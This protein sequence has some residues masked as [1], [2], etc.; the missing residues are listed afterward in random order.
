MTANF[1]SR[2]FAYAAPSGYKA[3]CTANLDPPTIADGSKYFDTKL[4]TGTN[5]NASVT[6]SG[7]KF[8]PDFIWA[9]SRSNPFSHNIYDIVRG[10]GKGLYSDNTGAEVTNNQYG[11]ISAFNSYGFTATPGSA[12]NDFFNGTNKTYVGWAWDAGDSTAPNTDGSI[13]S[14]VRAQPSAGFSIVTYTGGAAN[15]TVGHGLNAEPYVIICKSRTQSSAGWDVYHRSIGK[16]KFL[17]LNQNYAEGVYSNHWGTSGPDSTTF[18]VSQ[19]NYFNNHGDMVAYC[20]A[21]VEGYSA[22]GSYTGNGSD[23]GPFVFTGHSVA[24][25]MIKRSDAVDNWVIYD[26]ARDTYNIGGRRLYPDLTNLE[27]QNV[28]H[29]VDILSNGFKVRST[30]GMLNANGGN[31]IYMS[32]ASNPFKTTR[33]R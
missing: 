25:I 8:S 6:V 26:V 27:S 22:M 1:G 9:K 17:I 30:G 28:S 11:Y 10:T 20:F 33:A 14:Q 4:W 19:A 23:D 21:P 16:D 32:F 31:Y 2:A 5:T 15:S 3:L 13:T 12:D 24:W 7:Y 29:Y 18:G